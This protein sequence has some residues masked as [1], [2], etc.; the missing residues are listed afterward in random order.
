MA[1]Y[2]NEVIKR[3]SDGQKIGYSGP[4]DST[5]AYIGGQTNYGLAI[6]LYARTAITIEAAKYWYI[7]LEVWTSDVGGSAIAPFKTGGAAEANAH[8]YLLH[9]T[10][11]DPELQFA[12]GDLILE[13]V[14]PNWFYEDGV[15][16]DWVQ[17]T[18]VTD[19]TDVNETV[20]ALLVAVI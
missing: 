3:L 16:Y 2:G 4:S 18:Y 8:L 10:S 20:D 17:L 12:A 1:D 11:S 5:M 9:R 19:R 6:K 15:K 7:E 14:I 13:Y